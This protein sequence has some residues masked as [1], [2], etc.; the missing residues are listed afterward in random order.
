MKIPAGYKRK[1]DDSRIVELNSIGVSMTGIAEQLGV[2]HTTI[3]YRLKALGI[4]AVDTRR[5]FMEDVF[6]TLP[7][8]QQNWLIAQLGP[9]HSIKDFVRGLITKEYLNSRG[10]LNLN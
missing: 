2:H 6:N 8:N 5:A 10:L 3:T 9:G 1:A 4:S 7:S